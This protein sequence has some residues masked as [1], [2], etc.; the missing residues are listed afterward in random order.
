MYC[1][2]LVVKILIWEF[3]PV[4]EKDRAE[5]PQHYCNLSMTMITNKSNPYP[6]PYPYTITDKANS[7]EHIMSCVHMPPFKLNDF[8]CDMFFYLMFY[9]AVMIFGVIN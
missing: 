7:S 4:F 3:F 6:Y 8:K 2:F 5:L 1:E 9:L